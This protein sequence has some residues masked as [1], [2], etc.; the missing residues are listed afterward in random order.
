MKPETITICV[1][2]TFPG[3]EVKQTIL[4]DV[5]GYAFLMRRNDEPQTNLTVILEGSVGLIKQISKNAN[6]LIKAAA[7]DAFR[8]PP[9]DQF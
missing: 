7:I 8:L 4:K 5:E 1:T 6:D 2:R 9:E 3:G